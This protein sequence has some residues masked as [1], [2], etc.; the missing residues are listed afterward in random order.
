MS[1][2][3]MMRGLPASGKTTYARNLVDKGYVRVNKDDLRAMMHNSKWSDA[4]ETWILSTRDDIVREALSNGQSIIVDDTNFAPKHEATLR[5]F[6]KKYAAEFEIVDVEASLDECINR[7]VKRANGVGE[8]VIRDMYDRYV[9]P[10]PVVADYLPGKP[11]VVICDIDGTLA[12]GIG[13]TRRPYEWDKVGSDTADDVVRDLIGDYGDELIL[14]SGR[15]AS[16]RKLTEDWL[17][18]H[19]IIYHALYMRPAGDNRPDTEIKQEIYEKHI[20]G[21]FNVRFVLDDRDRV[22]ELWRSLG[23]KCLQVARGDF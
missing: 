16:C 1:K 8:K 19:E 14:V 23:L 18:V 13:V 11:H 3:I 7:D 20:K 4:R 2:L 15:D 6:A 9:R 21:K 22:V 12:H 10:A 17:A 5:A